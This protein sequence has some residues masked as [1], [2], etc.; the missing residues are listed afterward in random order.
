MPIRLS[1]PLHGRPPEHSFQHITGLRAVVLGWLNAAN[2]ALAEELHKMEGPKPYTISP[3]WARDGDR[4]FDI[5]L[6]DH[7]LLTPL[8]T[9]FGASGP[10]IRLG[11]QWFQAGRPV[12]QQEQSWEEMP[13][14]PPDNAHRLEIRLATPTAHHAPGPFRK[15]IVLPSPELY[16]GS[17][18]GR[19]NRFSPW[20]MDEAVLDLVAERVVVSAC[21][22][23]TCAV[24]MDPSRTF[25]GF[26]GVVLF[27]AL[28]PKTL[29]PGE[30]AALWAL[31][32]L[33]PFCG[34]GVETMRGMGQTELLNG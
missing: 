13:A 2:P 3:V 5:C 14:P 27:Q 34:T 26:Q 29:A 31:A 10:E 15:S 7:R 8:V 16:F 1:I 24:Q 11:N 32:R 30:L 12:V 22:G 25:I 6:L 21:E 33:A 20:I 28:K 17:W 19:W 4:G 23:R 9:G 18:F